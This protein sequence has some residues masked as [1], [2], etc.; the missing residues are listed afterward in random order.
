M[1]NF[2]KSRGFMTLIAVVLI[3]TGV[4]L[5]TASGGNTFLSK[6]LDFLVTPLQ[7][8]TTNISNSANSTFEDQKTID[9]LQ[10]EVNDLKQQVQNLRAVT[11]DYYDVKKENAQFLKY[12]DLKQ[13]DQS[14]KF[15]P[16]SVI[17]RD[18]NENFYGCT[19][20]EGSVAGVLLNDPVI[21]E[22]GLVGWVSHV[23]ANSCKVKT[24]L[25]PDTKVGAAD[26]STG[27]SGVITGG[28]PLADKNL[29]KMTCLLSENGIKSGDI[30]VTS[31]LSGIYP[32]NLQ[33]GEV[34]EITHDEYD[35]SLYALVK[36][37]ED[38]L[39]VKDVFIVTDFQGKA[40]VS[41]SPL[42]DQLE[43]T[44]NGPSAQ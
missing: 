44:K 24:I 40:Q 17:G 5:F 36:P 23:E 39:S 10:N 38:I 33:I 34:L 30:L 20:D 2:F 6:S 32:K 12:Y 14:L 31:G 13:K 19:L 16:A 29:T 3:L 41:V 18:S 1:S 26:I 21:T 11:V 37:F 22:N 8:L 28:L 27:D 25:S 7:K 35:A 15:V 4:L 9:E 42:K 43:Q